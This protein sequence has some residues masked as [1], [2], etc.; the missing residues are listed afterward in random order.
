MGSGCTRF[1]RHTPAARGPSLSALPQLC[2]L[3]TIRG[4]RWRFLTVALRSFPCISA[5][6]DGFESR[7]DHFSSPV[8]PDAYT[9][10]APVD[11]GR[12]GTLLP[13]AADSSRGRSTLSVRAVARRAHKNAVGQ[14]R[15]AHVLPPRRAQAALRSA[16]KARASSS[17]ERM[18]YPTSLIGAPRT[19]RPWHRRA[20][21]DHLPANALCAPRPR[22]APPH[23]PSGCGRCTQWNPSVNAV[24]D[25]RRNCYDHRSPG[26]TII[27]E[28][29][30]VDLST[31]SVIFESTCDPLGM[32][33]TT[34][35]RSSLYAPMA[36]DCAN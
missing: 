31:G 27:F 20:S 5:C 22:L 26:C 33:P 8:V 6:R 12:A 18:R 28:S 9:N 32:N 7:W 24:G 11:P 2:P 3:G 14:R 17:P 25:Q 21:R 10:C 19:M 36:A 13:H 16:Q 15:A 34:A 29:S 30:R 4:S 35:N 1:K 23:R